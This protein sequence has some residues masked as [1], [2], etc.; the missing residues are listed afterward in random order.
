MTISE[1]RR[2]GLATRRGFASASISIPEC[3]YH[4]P[5]RRQVSGDDKRGGEY[6]GRAGQSTGRGA[7]Q[8]EGRRR[9][10]REGGTLDPLLGCLPHTADPDA[11]PANPRRATRVNKRIESVLVTRSSVLSS[12]FSSTV[13]FRFYFSPTNSSSLSLPLSF[14]RS[15]TPSVPSL[16][17]Y[18]YSY[19]KFSTV[20]DSHDSSSPTLFPQLFYLSLLK[21]SYRRIQ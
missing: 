2:F 10:I 20:V 12:R 8:K 6:R 5:S 19:S 21:S 9:R 17:E 3:F 13:P 18:S 16:R 4:R 7:R 1:F 15:S 14:C 11:A